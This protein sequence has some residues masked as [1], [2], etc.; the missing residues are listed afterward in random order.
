MGNQCL[1]PSFSVSVSTSVFPVSAPPPSPHPSSLP[2]GF[3]HQTR[4]PPAGASLSPPGAHSVQRAPEGPARRQSREGGRRGQRLGVA[5]GGGLGPEPRNREPAPPGPEG[6]GQAGSVLRVPQAEARAEPSWALGTGDARGSPWGGHREGG[7]GGGAGGGHRHLRPASSA[8]HTTVPLSP[9]SPRRRLAPMRSGAAPRARPR[10]PDLTL[11][12]AGLESLVHFSFSDEDTRWHPPGRSVRWV[13]GGQFPP[14]PSRALAGGR[15]CLVCLAESPKWLLGSVW[16]PI[17]F[18]GPK[19]FGVAKGFL[20][21]I[22]LQ[23]SV[24]SCSPPV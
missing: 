8:R 9:C 12:P 11:P 7:C 1:S 22:T 4:T 24:R 20:Q 2:P 5:G 21:V 18:P 14:L 19:I 15:G 13:A 17:P 10:P 23:Q 3:C 6:G 16:S